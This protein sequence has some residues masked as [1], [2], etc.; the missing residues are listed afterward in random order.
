MEHKGAPEE[1]ALMYEGVKSELCISVKHSQS[2][3]MLGFVRPGY[4]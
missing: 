3:V 4:C 1:L 2:Q